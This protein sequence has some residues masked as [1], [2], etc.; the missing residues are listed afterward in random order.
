M[1]QLVAWDEAKQEVPA[2]LGLARLAKEDGGAEEKS[3]DQRPGL[4][5]LVSAGKERARCRAESG[6]GGR[7]AD[8]IEQSRQ[9]VARSRWERA[10]K[11][12]EEG[13]EHM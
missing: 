5:H 10:T 9:S 13:D 4:P 12:M 8:V 2:T 11:A 6:G 1:S 3:T 7:Q